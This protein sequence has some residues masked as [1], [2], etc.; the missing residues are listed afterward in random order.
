MPYALTITLLAGVALLALLVLL[1]AL[2]RRL[3]GAEW[4]S[5]GSW[6]FTPT[7]L[8]LLVLVP[9]AAIALR[10]FL[11]ALFVLPLLIPVL[12]RGRAFF[13]GRD[14][15]PDGSIDGEFRRVD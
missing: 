2:A 13:G 4:P 7:P 15:G 8:G 12:L 14:D 6:R 10:R 3:A 5:I 1:L 9:L 11:P